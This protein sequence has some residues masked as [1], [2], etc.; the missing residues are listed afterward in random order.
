MHSTFLF[1][2]LLKS[3]TLSTEA[4]ALLL[5]SGQCLPWVHGNPFSGC[6]LGTCSCLSYTALPMVRRPY[7]SQ[8]LYWMLRGQNPGLPHSVCNFVD[9]SLKLDYLNP[10]E[11]YLED[12]VNRTSSHQAEKRFHWNVPAESKAGG[13][14]RF[15]CSNSL[16]LSLQVPQIARLKPVVHHHYGMV[17]P[18][19]SHLRLPPPH[20]RLQIQ[21]LGN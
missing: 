6:S 10:R 21:T 1:N 19:H 18:S 7:G 4:L 9:L 11:D 8:V 17:A 2:S 13:S 16:A 14:E 5:L 3:G 20:I 15:S 12:L